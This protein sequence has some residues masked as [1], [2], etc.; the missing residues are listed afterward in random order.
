VL[1]AMDSGDAEGAEAAYQRAAR[2][3]D[4]AASKGV[5]HRN[6]A[7]NHKSRLARALNRESAA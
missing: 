5:I 6:N 7:A 3:Y 2:A 4:K 1:E